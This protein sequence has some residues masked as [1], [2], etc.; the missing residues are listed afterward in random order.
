MN[1]TRCIFSNDSLNYIN[2]YIEKLRMKSKRFQ[3]R[4]QTTILML[5]EK[6]ELKKKKTLT[7]QRR[8]V[9]IIVMN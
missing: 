7:Q 1:S 2:R 6:K 8:T 3:A 5:S 4:K 9:Q